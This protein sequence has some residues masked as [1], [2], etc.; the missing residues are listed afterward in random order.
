[1]RVTIYRSYR[2]E[3]SSYSRNNQDIIVVTII[4]NIHLLTCFNPEG[5][6]HAQNE[7]SSFFREKLKADLFVYFRRANGWCLFNV[8]WNQRQYIGKGEKHDS[9]E[10]CVRSLCKNGVSETH[11]SRL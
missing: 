6:L 7:L 5:I 11:E 4:N 9:L 8:A 1:M 3:E 10:E 2:N